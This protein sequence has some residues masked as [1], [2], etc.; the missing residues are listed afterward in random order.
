MQGSR[1]FA[2]SALALTLNQ[3]AYSEDAPAQLPEV[4]V[5]ATQA[6]QTQGYVSSNS[7]TATKTDTPLLETPVNVQV[8]PEKVLKDQ[9]AATLDQALI[10]VSGVVSNAWSVYGEESITMRGFQTSTVFVDGFRLIEYGGFG[11]RNLSNAQSVEVMKGPA[12]ILYGAIEPGGIVNITTKQPQAA[13]SFSIQQSVGSWDHYITDMDATGAVNEEK[14]LLYRLDATYDTTH[15][16][17]QG[18]WDKKAFV[19]PSLEWLVSP[20]T[21]VT[22]KIEHTHNPYS[23]DNAEVLPYFNGQIVPISK[24]QNLLYPYPVTVTTDRTDTRLGWS[25]EFNDD[26]T[27]KHQ[28]IKNYVTG[29]GAAGN[30]AGFA[31]AGG[32]LQAT[33]SPY[34]FPMTSD[35]TVASSLD[36]TGR[37]NTAG[38]KHTLLL[39]ADYYR[40]NNQGLILLPVG[41][42]TTTINV[43]SPA[44]VTPVAMDPNASSGYGAIT[45][46]KGAY[47]QDQIKLPN[48]VDVTA[49]F[50]YQHVDN[51]SWS[52]T[53]TSLGGN[54][55]VIAGTPSS[56]HALT[57]RLGLL[58][59]AQPWLSL[60][61]HYAGG[62]AANTGT[63]W[64]GQ[65]LKSSDAKEMEVGVK[66]EAPG[67]K[68]M[69]SLAYFDLT[70]T[71]IPTC[72]PNPQ[73]NPAGCNAAGPVPQ[74]TIGE[75]RSRG[76]EL[77]LKGEIQPNWNL[78]ITYAY[79][80]A[81]VS[82]STF[83]PASS[84][85]F[86][87]GQ[88]MPSTP[89]NMGSLW[90]TYDFKQ[91]DLAG[92]TMGG[93]VTV[94][95]S[96]MDSTN[97]IT[98]AGYAVVNAMASYQTKWGGSKVTAQFNIKNLF[99]REYINIANWA[100]GSGGNLINVSYSDPRSAMAS[101]KFEY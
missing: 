50:R 42:G 64:L 99:N 15:S 55:A 4:T 11:Q 17:R 77:D 51:T 9:Q 8:V 10:N 46:S 26:W 43:F 98:T 37:F 12:A 23:N 7:N 88:K 87:V 67:G 3:A 97:T 20:Q 81:R 91:G 19:A 27:I 18:D 1:L 68:L 48:H 47:V 79:T 86:L 33:Q 66:T 49:G 52:T 95:G 62:F 45:Y 78:I 58:W 53:G 101:L 34:A 13:T 30:V 36:V 14:T 92:W 40:V 73:H 21:Q 100:S 70:K 69:T 41:F 94:R 63:D 22:F 72:D 16:W 75:V 2:F 57:P 38:L 96:S 82:K 60:Y 29:T 65:P 71:N 44:P 54:N 5:T 56:D 24:S 85:S 89:N 39:G 76:V 74:T 31:Y 90:T 61:T 93:G 80:D 28:I 84:T 32:I 25:H 6:G 35:D 83:T 59:E